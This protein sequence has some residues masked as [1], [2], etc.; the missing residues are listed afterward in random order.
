MKSKTTQRL[1]VCLILTTA[2][3]TS[4]TAVTDAELEAIEKQIEQQEAV[5]DAELEAIEKQ[6]DQQEEEEKQSIELERRRLEQEQK[7]LA[8]QRRIEEEKRKAEEARLA[9]LERQRVEKEI[10]EE[11][12]QVKKRQ[13]D[14]FIAEAEQ[15][16]DKNNYDLAETNYSEALNIYNNDEKAQV[17]LSYIQ[18][19]KKRCL[20][21][22]G[23]WG[24]DDTNQTMTFEPDGIVVHRAALNTV[25]KQNWECADPKNFKFVMMNKNGQIDYFLSED[26]NYLKGYDPWGN[27]SFAKRKSE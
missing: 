18:I 7:K 4:V 14:K 3:L 13:Y 5:S 27:I 25:I 19:L 10:M 11:K 17:G 2:H 23:V 8:E 26:G 12:E 20:S 24:W 15:A 22:I 9:E 21:I 6:I 1:I 16:T